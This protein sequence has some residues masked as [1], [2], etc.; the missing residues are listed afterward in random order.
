MGEAQLDAVPFAGREDCAAESCR[1]SAGV[2]VCW[3][4]T[5]V[6]LCSP[7][8][9]PSTLHA[10][11]CFRRSKSSALLQP[12]RGHLKSR[13]AAQAPHLAAGRGGAAG[14]PR[15]RSV[16]GVL[17]LQ[18]AFAG[19]LA[20]QIKPQQGNALH[21]DQESLTAPPSHSLSACGPC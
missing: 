6:I 8:A 10:P 9:E 17:P 1:K 11:L 14:R 20:L 2:L 3:C 21:P 4:S 16:A 12:T 7:P 18:A 5:A 13:L 15:V 19:C